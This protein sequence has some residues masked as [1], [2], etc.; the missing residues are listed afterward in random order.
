MASTYTPGGIELIADGEQS[1]TWGDTTNTNWELI[2]EMVAGVV[3]IA[4]TSTSYTLTTSDGASSNGRHAVVV[5]TGSP[6]GTCTVTVS[7]NDL[8]K[9]YYI[10][11]STDQN[12]TLTQ[13]S[14]SN[15]TVT[16]GDTKIL[17]CDGAG[18][19]ANVV[20]V[21]S[22]EF[23]TLDATTANVTTANITTLNLGG[24]AVTSTAAELNLLDG[25]TSTTAELNILDGVTASA[26][27]LNTMDGITATTAELNIMDGVTATTAELNYVD[28]VTS[29]IQT[30]IDSKQAILTSSS[31]GYGTRTV[32]TSN[33]S[34]GSD[35]DIWYKVS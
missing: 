28:G 7:P 29:N 26:A 18:S 3:S 27:E 8:Q 34:G 23:T 30:Q 9:V 1:N 17:Y 15:V 11:N 32:S 5:F 4:L 12:V 16:S 25:V 20:S 19:S 13:G 24:A 35:G 33:P 14:G 22:S 6:G 10:K 31:N 21:I 2:E